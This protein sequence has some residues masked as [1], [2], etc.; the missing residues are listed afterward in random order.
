MGSKEFPFK[1]ILFCGSCGSRLTVEEHY[2]PL[3]DGTKRRHVY[4]RCTKSTKDPDCKEPSIKAEEITGQVLKLVESG[5]FNDI[6]SSEKLKK[7]LSA[8]VSITSQLIKD[9]GIMP[10]E[11]D[12]L[13]NYA[14]YILQQGS[15]D[16]KD[17]FIRGLNVPIFVT[18]K[19]LSLR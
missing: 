18:G 19:R 12:N 10:T 3:K 16:E 15:V 14:N 7:K 6:V 2:K 13:R 9:Y 8:Y 11:R 5:S 1:H 4:Y 17:V